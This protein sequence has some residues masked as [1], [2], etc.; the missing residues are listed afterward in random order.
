MIKSSCYSCGKKC[1]TSNDVFVIC[2][3]MT[4]RE[5]AHRTFLRMRRML[6][7]KQSEAPQYVDTIH[8][9]NH[10]NVYARNF[11]QFLNIIKVFK[12]AI[13]LNLILRISFPR[14]W[15][16]RSRANNFFLEATPGNLNALQTFLLI[17]EGNLRVILHSD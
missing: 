7:R 8:A 6:H 1:V 14:N 3:C 2:T 4:K 16:M 9:N 12:K 17:Q 13:E 5:L 10:L 11:P 15:N